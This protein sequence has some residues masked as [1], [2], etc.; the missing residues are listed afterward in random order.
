[1]AGHSYETLKV[2][3]SR[4]RFAEAMNEVSLASYVRRYPL[5]A[6][7]AAA[8]VGFLSNRR[9][10]LGSTANLATLLGAV[11]RAL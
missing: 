5:R 6:A 3:E 9:F 1:M 4:R 11:A 2:I 8:A 7:G 10:R